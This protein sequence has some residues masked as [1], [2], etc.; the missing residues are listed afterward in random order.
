MNNR[1][2]RIS[3]ILPIALIIIPL[4]LLIGCLYIPTGEMVY[5]TGS[6]KDFRPLVGNAG[7]DKP[8]VVG[9]ISRA[10]VEA[11]LGS[12]PYSSSNGR[13]V[14]YVMHV[15]KGVWIMPLCFTASN[16]TDQAIGLVLTYDK[17]AMLRSL[18]QSDVEFEQVVLMGIHQF[19]GPSGAFDMQKA[20][21]MELLRQVNSPASSGSM[22]TTHPDFAQWELHP[23][24]KSK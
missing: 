10:G 19:F 1:R 9:R 23:V 11:I 5:R 12:P 6:K 18:K 3:V 20:V 16:G 22:P 21:E 7:G 14:M 4:W 13:R 17:A 8:I 24:S 15:K 2:F